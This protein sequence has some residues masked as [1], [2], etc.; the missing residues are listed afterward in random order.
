MWLYEQ[1]LTVE[2]ADDAL[3]QYQVTYQPDRRHVTPF[4]EPRLF[5]TPHR[6]PQPPLWGVGEGEWLKVLRLPDDA[7]RRA[8]PSRVGQLPLFSS[9]DA[10]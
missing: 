3:A 7:T 1:T 9:E 10:V 5:E 6:S 8:R 2:F 4:T